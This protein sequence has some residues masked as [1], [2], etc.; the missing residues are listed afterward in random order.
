MTIDLISAGLNNDLVKLNHLLNM[1]INPDFQEDIFGMTTLHYAIMHG[2]V[3]AVRILI[4]YGADSEVKNTRGVTARELSYEFFNQQICDIL[5]PE[6]AEARKFM[7]GY[8]SSLKQQY[9]NTHIFNVK[10][11]VLKN[12]SAD[13][14]QKEK[15]QIDLNKDNSSQDEIRNEV[16]KYVVNALQYMTIH[17]LEA[18]K[19]GK[20]SDNR[21]HD[22]FLAEQ[23]LKAL[24]ACAY[25]LRE[26]HN[27][28]TGELP[29]IPWKALALYI[30]HF[31]YNSNFAS[32][33]EPSY[34]QQLTHESL[35]SMLTLGELENIRNAIEKFINDKQSNSYSPKFLYVLTG[36]LDDEYSIKQIKDSLNYYITFG[37]FSTEKGRSIL[38]SSLIKIGEALEN[39]SL[40]LIGCFNDEW[41]RQIKEI[42]T[43]LCHVER[44]GHSIMLQQLL[45]GESEIVKIKGALINIRDLANY[46]VCNQDAIDKYSELYQQQIPSDVLWEKIKGLSSEY[47]RSSSREVSEIEQTTYS[48]IQN[49]QVSKSKAR[50]LDEQQELSK[51]LEERLIQKLNTLEQKEHKSMHDLEEIQHIKE[52]KLDQDNEVNREGIKQKLKAKFK[53]YFPVDNVDDKL[54]NPEKSLKEVSKAL[55]KNCEKYDTA[56]WK[57]D[58]SMPLDE[59]EGK[60]LK[61]YTDVLLKEQIW[62]AYISDMEDLQCSIE[63]QK[64]SL[65]KAKDDVI[66]QKTISL[67]EDYLYYANQV[68]EYFNKLNYTDSN[69]MLKAREEYASKGFHSNPD[70]NI[71]EFYQI[72]VGSI[73]RGLLGIQIFNNITPLELNDALNKTIIVARGYLAHIGIRKEGKAF[74]ESMDSPEVFYTNSKKTIDTL[75]LIIIV[76]YALE[77]GLAFEGAK[78]CIKAL[79]WPTDGY[80][81]L[82]QDM[83][84]DVEDHTQNNH[85]DESLQNHLIENVYHED[86]N[87]NN[88]RV[89]GRI[90][91]NTDSESIERYLH[92]EKGYAY[93]ASSEE[94][95]ANE[96]IASNNIDQYWRN[97]LGD[98]D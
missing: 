89:H 46:L 25:Y 71:I 37:N 11:K 5:N 33:M 81:K 84:E 42:R 49:Y 7:L 6:L 36:F 98:N 88:Q 57:Q 45:S 93:Y 82:T 69:R 55:D 92:E 41:V 9:I 39:A 21:W 10:E 91:G 12:I 59:E 8:I 20:G 61:N 53:K 95:F 77:N 17:L 28:I 31:Q 38:L 72:M 14:L 34:I 1:G 4:D 18:E 80:T 48:I 16:L 70:H 19:Y 27:N 74:S 44:P 58:N 87:F 40:K 26:N 43:F 54:K 29:G 83:N 79:P 60:L 2:H 15:V 52:F 64:Q 32:S 76:K 23:M 22:D 56:K 62:K 75:P 94:V 65:E 13:Y 3:E 78:E 50:S 86:Q 73:A 90:F 96:D 68:E 47:G 67:L 66:K 63:A 35:H 30:R 97:I 24:S 51:K 85:F